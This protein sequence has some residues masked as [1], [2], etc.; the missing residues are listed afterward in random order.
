MKIIVGLG[1]P[2]EQ[3][4]NTRHNIG[5]LALDELFPNSAWRENKKFNALIYESGDFLC[6]KPL[7]FM[8]NSGQAVQKILN[9]YKLIP[10]NFG[11]VNKKNANL[12]DSLTVIHDDLDLSF[13]AIK[14]STDSTS[15]GH[16]GVQSIIDYLQTKKF[17]RVRLGIKNDLLRTHIPPE[18]FVIQ[19]FTSEEKKQLP[20][21]FNK[22]NLENLK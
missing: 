11:L 13:G 22:I 15:A 8:N 14:I 5:W 19:P 10:K 18:K 16:R 7:T 6:I 3:Y 17:T 20:D 12:S 2:G 1:N 21:I 4:H 9:Y